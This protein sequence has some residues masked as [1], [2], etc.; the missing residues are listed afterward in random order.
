MKAT[1]TMLK[2]VALIAFAAGSINSFAQ[3]RTIMYV[4]KNGTVIYQSA[5]SDID[6]AT[7]DK[8]ASGDAL[9]LQKNDNSAEDKILL[10]N[11]QQLSFSE[12]SLFIE[13]SSGSKAYSFDNIT[14]LLWGN[15]T[16]INNPSV[17]N[18]FDVIAYITPAG[19]A[20]VES[21]AAIH[22][23]TVFGIDGKMISKQNC[24]GEIQCE[25]SLQGKAAGVY[26]LRIETEHD[27][28]IKKV[29]KPL[30]K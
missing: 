25:V 4:M 28:V 19:D 16:G 17:K 23:V 6:N 22:S 2:I 20:M 30:N 12:D 14:K 10:N 11:I 24:K 9:I 1:V 21:S 7:F 13:T 8:A 15:N 5:V 26:L 3:T 27:T 29:V 18:G